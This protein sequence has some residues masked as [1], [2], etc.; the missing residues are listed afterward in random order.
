MPI[1][2]NKIFPMGGPRTS[3]QIQ[4]Q[5]EP[6]PDDVL[7]PDPK[8]AVPE[9]E[10]EPEPVTFSEAEYMLAAMSQSIEDWCLFTDV[11]KE[12]LAAMLTTVNPDN[13][14]VY[15]GQAKQKN[16]S[17][18]LLLNTFAFQ[19]AEAFMLIRNRVKNMA[20]QLSAQIDAENGK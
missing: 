14:R 9:P 3:P 15:E 17:V 20:E 10:P 11:A 2:L 12:S 13:A 8:D 7:P 5:P 16:I 1:D 4:P 6:E 18:E 19:Y